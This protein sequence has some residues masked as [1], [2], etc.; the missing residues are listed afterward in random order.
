MPWHIAAN[1]LGLAFAAVWVGWTASVGHVGWTAIIA[2]PLFLTGLL[3]P[4]LA[5]HRAI[6][7][8]F[9]RLDREAAERRRR[10]RGEGPRQEVFGASPPSDPAALFRRRV[11]PHLPAIV[12]FVVAA[13][14]LAGDAGWF[15]WTGGGNRGDEGV[16][17]NF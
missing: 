2:A 13:A 5:E 14:L 10:A 1:G 4:F 9:D 8:S 12:L 6:G 16:I 15:V 11:N 3:H 17:S 7:R